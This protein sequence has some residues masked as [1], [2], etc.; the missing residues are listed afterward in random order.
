MTSYFDYH[1]KKPDNT[2][3]PKSKPTPR[4]E[5]IDPA[6]GIQVGEETMSQFHEAIAALRNKWQQDE[7]N[8]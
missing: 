2:P 3:A 4:H 8:Q 6:D 1:A 7:Q 5:V